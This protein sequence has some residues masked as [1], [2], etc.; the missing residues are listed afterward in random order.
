MHNKSKLP[1]AARTWNACG[2]VRYESGQTRAKGVS[3]LS[4]TLCNGLA[5]LHCFLNVPEVDWGCVRVIY[6]AIMLSVFRQSQAKYAAG[7]LK[8][9]MWKR[10]SCAR[11]LRS[12]MGV[13]GACM[14]ID[15][16][17]YDEAWRRV[18]GNSFQM[19]DSFFNPHDFGMTPNHYVFFQVR[20]AGDVRAYACH[21]QV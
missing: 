5:K 9:E 21:L 8:P 12:Q 11:A 10:R 3:R 19:A 15:I 1:G 6:H 18:G 4:Q 13:A 20:G 7:L 14:R 16:A 17:E 2:S